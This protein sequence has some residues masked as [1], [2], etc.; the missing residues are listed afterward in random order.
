MYLTGRKSHQIVEFTPYKIFLGL[1]CNLKDIDLKVHYLQNNGTQCCVHCVN[2]LLY[3]LSRLLSTLSIFA[4]KCYQYGSGRGERLAVPVKRTN[5]PFLDTFPIYYFFYCSSFLCFIFHT[6]NAQQY[7]KCISV[8]WTQKAWLKKGTKHIKWQS[9]ACREK[10]KQSELRLC[11]QSK[12]Q[13]HLPYW[14][15]SIQWAELPDC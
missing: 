4:G 7:G 3:Y 15:N 14:N 8:S 1:Y 6:E 9:R 11:S 13:L 10:T 5:V 12:P 2:I